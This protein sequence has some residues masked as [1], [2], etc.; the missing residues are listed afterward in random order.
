MIFM[1]KKRN[2]RS[3][4]YQYFQ[5]ILYFNFQSF[6]IY[7]L[8]Q[9]NKETNESYSPLPS[10]STSKSLPESSHNT[11]AIIVDEDKVDM[12]EVDEDEI[13]DDY[14]YDEQ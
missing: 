6:S 13:V 14:N 8:F 10:Q 4:K 12:N 5:T 1:M 9:Q 3:I 7:L 2:Y 11:E